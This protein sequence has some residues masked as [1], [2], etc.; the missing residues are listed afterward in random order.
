MS[1]FVVFKTWFSVLLN[2]H[3]LLISNWYIDGLL[4]FNDTLKNS[5]TSWWSVSLMEETGASQT[6][7]NHWQTLSEVLA[8][9]HDWVLNSQL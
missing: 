9:H 8:L 6:C 1:I 2:I 5:V 3:C 7:Y 4:L